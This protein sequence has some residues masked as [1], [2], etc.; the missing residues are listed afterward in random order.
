MECPHSPTQEQALG[1]ASGEE[2]MH[3]QSY[4]VG[5][6]PLEGTVTEAGERCGEEEGAEED[7]TIERQEQR[8]E[9]EMH[10]GWRGDDR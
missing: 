9:K 10:Q 5:L 4:P 3:E 1:R 7:M 2:P 6:Q 8:K